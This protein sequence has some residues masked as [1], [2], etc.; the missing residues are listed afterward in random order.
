MLFVSLRPVIFRLAQ[1]ASSRCAPCQACIS[2]AVNAQQS[3]TLMICAS[4]G[5]SLCRFGVP[6]LSEHEDDAFQTPC[7][8]QCPTRRRE[9]SAAQCHNVQVE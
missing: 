8:A 1:L 5:R 7:F 6:P 9:T 4:T 2:T 3:F